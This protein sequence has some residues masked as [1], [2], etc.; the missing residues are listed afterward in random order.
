MIMH[1]LP[2]LPYPYD[3]LE[4]YIDAETM[5]LHHGKHHQ[6]YV[7]KLNAALDKFPEWQNKK[8]AELLKNLNAV[9]EVIRTTVR[10]HGGGHWNHSFFWKILG[11]GSTLE[12]EGRTLKL[13]L[14][15]SFGA[16]DEFQKQFKDAALNR[17]GSGWAWLI[18]R[19]DGVLAITS[20]ANQ[21][22]PFDQGQPIL[23]LDVWEHAYYLKYQNRRADYIDAFFKIINW[24]EVV[25]GL[26]E[27]N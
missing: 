12:D 22:I 23:G 1:T 27:K 13:T 24:R 20:T 21:D 4:P 17:F 10:N 7:D 2:P 18:K 25:R 6:G 8:L 3:A 5:R 26:T 14:E 9:P 15:K 19:V 16:V 11:Q